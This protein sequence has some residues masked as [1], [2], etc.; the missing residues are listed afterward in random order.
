[1]KVGSLFSGIGGIELGFEAEGFETAWFVEKEPYAQA[2]LK[3]HWPEAIIYEDVTTIDWRTVP[4]VDVLTGGFP[5][6]DI[7]NA[8][9]R[10]GIEG[11]RSSLWRHYCEA[12]RVLRPKYAFIENVSALIIRGLDVV[13]ADLTSIGYDAEWY[14]VSASSVGALHRRERLFIITYSN[15]NRESNESLDEKQGQRFLDEQSNVA[16]ANN[17]GFCTSGHGS[18]QGKD[19]IYQDGEASSCCQREERQH[20]TGKSCT[21]VPNTSSSGLEGQR[22]SERVQEE[23]SNDSFNGWWQAEPRICRVVDGLP[24]R[25]D[26]I[27]CLGNG[28]VPQVAQVFAKAIKESEGVKDAD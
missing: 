14:T 3:K 1:M 27:K 18:A 9:K 8:G 4:K 7:S 6:Q 15:C 23:H 16:H 28:V 22:E 13:L 26:R 20:E 21:D 19:T 11:S 24:N 10:A 5:C 12:I 17:Y 2:I 25:V